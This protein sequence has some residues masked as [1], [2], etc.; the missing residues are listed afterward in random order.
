MNRTATPASKD[1]NQAVAEQ[2][3]EQLCNPVF[4][5]IDHPVAIIC[6]HPDDETIGIGSRLPRMRKVTFLQVTDGAPGAMSDALRNGFS[7]RKEYSAARRAE[8]EAALALGGVTRHQLHECGIPDQEATLRMTAV[9]RT[10][11]DF[12]ERFSPAVLITHPYE[13]GHPDHDATAFAVHAACSLA[14]QRLGRRPAIVEMTSYHNRDGSLA[15]GA[16]LESTP[17]LP[18]MV[19]QLT[20]D[21]RELKQRMFACFRSQAPVLAQFPIDAERFRPAPRYNFTRAPHSGTLFYELHPW[22]MT[23][24]RFRAHVADALR[25]LGLTA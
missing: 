16:F 14:N 11:L 15:A 4:E 20:P 8:L 9:T 1:D 25:E 3:L 23:G 21:E 12:L 19:A 5:D 22:G 13:G 10:V 24:E 7:S 6:A 17:A 18:V 2:F